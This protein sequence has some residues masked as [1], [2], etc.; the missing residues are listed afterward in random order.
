MADSQELKGRTAG[1]GPRGLALIG[2]LA[3][4]VGFAVALLPAI[5]GSGGFAGAYIAVFSFV[6]LTIIGVIVIAVGAV[7]ALLTTRLVGIALM[8][9]PATFLVGY[10]AGYFVI[11]YGLY[12]G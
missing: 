1:L 7:V 9:G 8:L 12:Y 10:E 2:L 5:T 3:G 6:G 4:I 11:L